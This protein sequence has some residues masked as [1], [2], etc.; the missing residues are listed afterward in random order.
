MALR[1]ERFSGRVALVTGAASGIGRE[2]ARQLAAEGASVCCADLNQSAVEQTADLIAQAGHQASAHRLDVAV[3]A[4]WEAVMQTIQVAHGRLDVLVNCAGISAGAPLAEMSYADWRRVLSV[5]LD[6][7]FLA[8]KYGLRAMRQSGGS[9]VHVSSASGIKASAGACAYSASKAGLCMLA[10]AAAKE[11]RDQGIPVRVNAVCPGGVKTPI[12]TTMPFF[13][14]LVQKAGSEEAAFESL[15]KGVAGGQFSDPAD[16][17]H[18]ILFLASDES[19]F[20]TGVDLLVDGGYV[21]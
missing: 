17:A 13:R 3:E 15:A 21:L 2:T 16:V 4:E 8:T 5:N 9:I 7:A 11:C 12:W 10:K 14:E 20:V 18:A 19:R 6:G 1:P